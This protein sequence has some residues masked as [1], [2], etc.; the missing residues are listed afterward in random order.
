MEAARAEAPD[1]PAWLLLRRALV[2]AT[3][4]CSCRRLAQ[5]PVSLVARACALAYIADKVSY[6]VGLA[7]H[8]FLHVRLRQQPMPLP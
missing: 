8:Y 4:E 6:S 2:P 5:T 3:R 7:G 1:G